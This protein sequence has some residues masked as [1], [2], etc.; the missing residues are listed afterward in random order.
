[1]NLP[2]LGTILIASIAVAGCGGSKFERPGFA[3]GCPTGDN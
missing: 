1:M 2:V 3:Y